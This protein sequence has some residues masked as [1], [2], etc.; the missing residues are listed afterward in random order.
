MRN[1]I[2]TGIDLG[3]EHHHQTKE[4]HPCA[5]DNNTGNTAV[6]ERIISKVTSI[7]G[8]SLTD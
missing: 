1:F 6:H 8:E 4:I 7:N 5:D 2:Q 3:T